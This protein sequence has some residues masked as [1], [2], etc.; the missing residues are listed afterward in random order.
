MV[1]VYIGREEEVLSDD[2]VAVGLVSGYVYNNSGH[3]IPV[4]RPRTHSE[5]GG[6]VGPGMRGMQKDSAN[7]VSV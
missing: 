1:R 5:E 4:T 6:F 3:S 7:H 2:P